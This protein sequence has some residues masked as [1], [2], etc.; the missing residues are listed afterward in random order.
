VYSPSCPCPDYDDWITLDCVGL[1]LFQNGAN[2]IVITVENGSSDPLNPS[3]LRV[4]GTVALDA[5]CDSDGGQT[6]PV[7][8]P[9]TAGL[10]ALSGLGLMARFRRRRI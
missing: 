2:D 9:A 5:C 10:V 4:E 3:G 7:P 8:E 1:G 6:P